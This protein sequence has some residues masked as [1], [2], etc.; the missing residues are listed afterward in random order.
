[1]PFLEALEAFEGPPGRFHIPGHKGGPGAAPE[2]VEVFGARAVEMD[3]PAFPDI[4]AGRAAAEE[5]A[6]AAW[7]G[8][9]CWFVT[10][11][12][13][14]ANHAAC[15]ALAQRGEEVLVGRNL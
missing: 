14:Q 4:V 2:L 6:A 11:G 5:L 3:I 12:A 13:S 10:G 7:S 9:R 15:L 8:L 1:M